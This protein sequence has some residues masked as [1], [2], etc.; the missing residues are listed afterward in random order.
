MI[1]EDSYTTVCIHCKKP[2]QVYRKRYFYS[3]GTNVFATPKFYICANRTCVDC[4]D[5]IP[6]KKIIL[7]D[8]IFEWVVVYNVNS[9]ITN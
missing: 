8:E 9:F 1:D 6:N 5:I 3:D 4:M 7:L 2:Q